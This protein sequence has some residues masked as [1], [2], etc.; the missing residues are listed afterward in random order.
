[1]VYSSIVSSCFSSWSS[2]KGLGYFIGTGIF[3]PVRFLV[4]YFRIEKSRVNRALRKNWGL[5][6]GWA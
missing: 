4:F 1:M 5:E 3:A 6:G 2:N